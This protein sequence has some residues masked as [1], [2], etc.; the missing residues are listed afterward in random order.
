MRV[1]VSPEKQLCIFWSPKA[2]SAS[3]VKLFFEYCNFEY[4]KHV[5]IHN[6][7]ERYQQAIHQSKLPDDF[8]KYLKIQICRN[9]YSR[10]VSSYMHL[11]QILIKEGS[12]DIIKKSL[13]DIPRMFSY[14]IKHSTT[15][16]I[17]NLHSYVA[18]S[19]MPQH[20]IDNIDELI[21]IENFEQSINNI[22]I[23]YNINLPVAKYLNHS[24]K[25]TMQND[26]SKYIDIP[27]RFIKLY[28]DAL[29][30]YEKEFVKSWFWKDFE[31]FKYP[32]LNY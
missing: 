29:T 4:D 32:L 2:G 15:Y 20:M 26:I 22:N 7:R 30:D 11:A 18:H 16:D 1:L 12:H 24:H 23:K 14:M 31:F 17:N 5:W 27:E 21:L 3:A 9:P 13:Y 28:S 6:E 25:I 19:L 10:A 8:K